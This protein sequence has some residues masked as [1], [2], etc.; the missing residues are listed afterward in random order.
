MIDYTHPHAAQIL[1]GARTILKRSETGARLLQ[2][3]DLQDYTVQ[4]FRII[5]PR[6]LV[7]D[8]KNI[9]IGL[10]ATQDYADI[11][12]VID[13]AAALYEMKW[14]H[15]GKIRPADDPDRQE[16]LQKQHLLNLEIILH[17]F[18]VVEELEMEGY[19]AA[20]SLRKQSLT[21][22]YRAWLRQAP[23]EEFINLY[24]AMF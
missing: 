1:E 5:Y 2:E 7:P 8:D 20:D 3:A 12:Q 9:Y 13:L 4:I 21:P 14:R 19:K 10:P 22:L 17:T 23:Y 6:I 16:N 18:P 15:E 24:W 11:E